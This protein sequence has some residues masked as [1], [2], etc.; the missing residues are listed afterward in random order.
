MK[1]RSE[2]RKSRVSWSAAEDDALLKAVLEDK[3][4]RESEG[5]DVEDEED[6]DEIAKHIPS[7][8]PVQCL[9]RYMVINRTQDD[10]PSAP[11]K[12]K[13]TTSTAAT[14]AAET[15][16]ND[17]TEVDKKIEPQEQTAKDDADADFDEEEEKEAKRPR[18]EG[19]S[20]S[21]WPQDDLDLL[22]KLVENYKDS[23][24]RWNEIAAN[25]S[26]RYT[27]IDCLTK[28]Q[29]I[30]NPPVIKGKG[31]WTAEEDAILRE[32]RRQYGRKWAK[33]AAHLPGRQGKQ[34]RERFVNHLDPE[35]KKGE[36][37]DDEE[38]ILIAMHE[39]HG[40]RWA[41]ISKQLPGRSDNDVKNHWYSTIQRKFQQHGKEKLISAALQQVQMMQSMG[42]M[43]SQQPTSQSQ[44]P[45]GPY[46]QATSGH[47]PPP[48]YAHHPSQPAAQP[49][50]HASPGAGGYPYHPPPHAQQGRPPTGPPEG[51]AYM[52]PHQHQPP[53]Q[54]AAHMPPHHAYYHHYPP[55]P[56]PPRH[57]G[58]P[59]TTS[60]AAPRLSGV[61]GPEAAPTG[62]SNKGNQGTEGSPK[63][64]GEAPSHFPMQQEGGNQG[65]KK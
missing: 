15:S 45:A 57:G 19:E 23:A 29:T 27:A 38:A 46:N 6:W 42:T 4:D 53:H 37:T 25:F 1:R 65:G 40:N 48:P 8:T 22:K 10:E 63:D 36:W 20:S 13:S 24:P 50:Q 11:S 49:Y 54:R 52:Y 5:G 16:T 3:R 28:W 39:H 43:P 14:A 17:N 59:H 7:K 12:S 58:A 55:P 60:P 32:K 18:K 9:K 47:P 64:S 30:T 61:V 35:L 21:R 34:C 31:S 41:N 44:W 56:L 62:A 26:N 33:I 2:E 51:A